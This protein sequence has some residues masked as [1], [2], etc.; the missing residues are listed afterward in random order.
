MATGQIHTIMSSVMR[1]FKIGTS[2][3]I[4]GALTTDEA[5]AV[6]GKIGTQA[7]MIPLRIKVTRYNDPNLAGRVYNCRIVDNQMLTSLLLRTGVSALVQL[8]GALPADNTLYYKGNIELDDGRKIPFDNVSTGQDVAEVIRDGVSPVALLMD[9]PY[10]KVKIKSFD[11]DVQVTDKN[12]SA[13]IWSVEL[14]QS[15]VKPGG[16]FNVDVVLARFLKQKQ[17]YSFNFVV[18]KDTPAGM[19]QLV[20]CGGYEYEEFIKRAMPF[21][22]TPENLDTLVVAINGILAVNRDGLYC[23]LILPDGGV[24]LERAELPELPATKALVL[25]DASRDAKMQAYPGW[26]EQ[27][28]R[29]GFILNN[30]QVMSVTVEK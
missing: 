15:K 6:R 26:L 3:K 25:G 7:R 8:R 4:V 30:Q 1:S 12:V 22:F 29:T 17:K 28:I 21:R 20:V 23:M 19:Y 10:N 9:N 16:Q 2:T 18:P 24:A 5:A 13:G 14:S 27:K 11:L